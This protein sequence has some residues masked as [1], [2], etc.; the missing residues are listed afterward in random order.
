MQDERSLE[1][2]L[3]LLQTL[4]FGWQAMVLLKQASAELSNAAYVLDAVPRVHAKVADGFAKRI[5][6]MQSE[7]ERCHSELNDWTR[8]IERS[9][10]SAK[11]YTV[12]KW[13]EGPPETWLVLAPGAVEVARLTSERAAQ[14]L[15]RTYNE[16]A[17]R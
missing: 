17:S 4:R 11:A 5:R 1:L 14:D 12:L 9:A 6:E 10:L 7:A 3:R 8:E 2:T 16:G 13:N 15:A